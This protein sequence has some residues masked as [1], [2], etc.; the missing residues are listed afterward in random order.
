MTAQELHRQL[1]AGRINKPDVDR[2]VARV[3]AS[4]EL[5]GPL[6]KE[7]GIHDKEDNFAASWIFDHVMRKKLELI[8]PLLNDFIEGLNQMQSE[9]SIRP[10][11]HICQLLTQAYYKAK[12]PLFIDALSL[13]HLEKMATVCFDWLIEEH[14][15]ATKVFAMT[16]LFHLG[17]TFDW[18]RPELKSVLEQHIPKG[19]AGFQNRGIKILNKLK[20]LGY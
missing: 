20:K 2:I 17:K 16:S 4:P 19:S 6:F 1:N 12:H 3:L 5:V 14:K 7:V 10:M 18:I 13:A 8:I 9:S 11:A 15:V